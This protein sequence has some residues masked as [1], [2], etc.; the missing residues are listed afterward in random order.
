M[1]GGREPAHIFFHPFSRRLAGPLRAMH[2][3]KVGRY[4]VLEH[5][6][7]GA[8]SDVYLA[9]DTVL[10]RKVALKLLRVREA[11]PRQLQ[12]F[13]REAHCA[14]MLNHPNVV[15]VYDI[16]VDDGVHYIAS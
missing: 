8:S 10:R 7:R 13:E 5:L 6:G 1:T 4:R 9:E 14:S 3:L 2:V 12:R 11:E 16:G 15:T